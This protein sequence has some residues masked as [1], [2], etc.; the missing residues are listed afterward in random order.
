MEFLLR[1][2]N[3]AEVGIQ[4]QA[5]VPQHPFPL[6][7]HVLDFPL[8]Q[9]VGGSD[10]RAFQQRVHALFLEGVIGLGLGLAGNSFE[11]VGAKSFHVVKP[12]A[13]TLGEFIIQ[14][15][16][17]L[18][19]Y[20]QD[21]HFEGNFLPGILGPRIL[22]RNRHGEVLVLALFHVLQV[23]GKA[24]EGEDVGDFRDVVHFLVVD[25]LLAIHFALD[26]EI[27]Q[28]AEHDRTGHGFPRRHFAA[29]P[30][31]DLVNL[32]VGNFHR[33]LFQPDTVELAQVDGGFQGNGG[34]EGDGLQFQDFNSRLHK[35]LNL[36]ILQGLV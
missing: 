12:F 23:L 16:Q 11:N 31:Q 28:V 22:L 27:K 25:H 17:G 19:L 4:V 18:L 7:L 26:V 10:G 36:F 29:N 13:D 33:F 24:G 20:R 14:V 2:A 35:G 5:L 32:V 15:C 34:L 8:N 3:V 6:V 1:L 9:Q 30:L 21:L